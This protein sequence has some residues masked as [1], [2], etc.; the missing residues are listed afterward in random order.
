MTALVRVFRPFSSPITLTTSRPLCAENQRTAPEV[1]THTRGACSQPREARGPNRRVSGTEAGDQ[2]RV[3]GGPAQE[4]S[5][6]SHGLPE[7]HA[8]PAGL[9]GPSDG[10][11]TDLGRRVLLPPDASILSH[12]FWKYFRKFLNQQ[13]FEFLK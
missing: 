1:C 3:A 6:S 5:C 10:G 2:D 13:A 9:G 8:A 7:G 12:V 4:S 11:R